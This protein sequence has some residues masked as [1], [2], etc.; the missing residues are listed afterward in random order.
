MLCS[1]LVFIRSWVGQEGTEYTEAIRFRT[2]GAVGVEQKL[3]GA[4]FRGDTVPAN[5]RPM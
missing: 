5:V 1:K 2:V 3:E 4:C